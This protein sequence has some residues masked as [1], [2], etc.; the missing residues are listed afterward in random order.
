MRTMGFQVC[1]F[2]LDSRAILTPPRAILTPHPNRSNN[3]IE[4][5]HTGSMGVLTAAVSATTKQRYQTNSL[6]C[7]HYS[8]TT[9]YLKKLDK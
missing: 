2:L 7:L 8:K 9:L 1:L 6:S 3:I 4:N 5:S